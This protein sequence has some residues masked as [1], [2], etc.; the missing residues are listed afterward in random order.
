MRHHRQGIAVVAVV[1]HLVRDD[2][3]MLGFDD[4]LHV[5]A[6]DARLLARRRHGAAVGVGQRHLRLA[7]GIHALLDGA[8]RA[9][10]LR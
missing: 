2:Q 9:A 8:K 3:M 5:V 6:D 4:A 10:S 1:R 7:G